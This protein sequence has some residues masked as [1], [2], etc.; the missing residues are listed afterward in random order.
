M[1][2]LHL[3]VIV[4]L[5]ILSVVI[6]GSYLLFFDSSDNAAKIRDSLALEATKVRERMVEAVAM[7]IAD[8][9]E[10]PRVQG[11]LDE[12][13]QRGINHTIEQPD[14]G[15]RLRG[16][17]ANM[18]DDSREMSRAMGEQLPGLAVSFVSGAVSSFTGK[19]N[20]SA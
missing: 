1:M 5:A 14:L 9:L 15:S 12:T 19:K 13:F 20:K 4:H 16:V 3:A 8:V 17:Y 10:H 18:E 2:L 7:F 11:V 6:Y